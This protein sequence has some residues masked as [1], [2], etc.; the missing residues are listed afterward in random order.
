M[1]NNLYCLKSG[2]KY[3]GVIMCFGLPVIVSTKSLTKA[4]LYEYDEAV[5]VRARL[6]KKGVNA[7]IIG[8]QKERRNFILFLR[9]KEKINN[10]KSIKYATC[11][12]TH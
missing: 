3:Y 12:H 4:C 10:F 7:E 2:I 9:K 8:E 1:T 11:N 5:I 6:N